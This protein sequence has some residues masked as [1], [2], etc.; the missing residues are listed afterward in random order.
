MRLAVTG[1]GSLGTIIG[2]LITKK[3]GDPVLIDINEDHVRALNDRGAT[4]TGELDL[5]VPVRA[6]TPDQMTGT[7][8]VV[9]Y[10][11]KQYD[12]D[13][14]LEQLLPHIGP[15]SVVCT[16]QNGLPEKAVARVIGKKRTIGCTVCWGATW[17]GP[18][19]SMLTSPVDTMGFDVGELDGA[20]T[21]RLGSLASILGLVCPTT[22]TRNLAGIRWAK[23]LANAAYSGTA[24]VLGSTMGKVLRHPKAALCAAH[25]A[26]ETICVSRA[27]GIAMEP[28]AGQDF[29][30]L[31]FKNKEELA[32]ALAL[33][34]TFWGP[35]GALKPSMLQDLEKGRRCEIDAINGMVSMWGRKVKVLTPVNDWVV[36]IVRGIEDGLYKP[37]FDH[38]E[39][40]TLPTIPR[41]GHGGAS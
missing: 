20:M 29:T 8:H 39:K 5:T 27:L 41:S 34:Q 26:N 28:V 18:G 31:A 23:L 38:L 3:G 4:I 21:E 22:M 9:L 19:V 2:A 25:I 12:N 10:A 14:A 40:I 15:A 17:M 35:Q 6:I 33:H 32:V 11:V 24:S 30:G 16:L 7:Y 1:A 37:G 36:E 13:K